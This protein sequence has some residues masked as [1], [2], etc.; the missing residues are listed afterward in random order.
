VILEDELDALARAGEAAKEQL[1]DELVSK[2][3]WRDYL[4]ATR[5]VQEREVGDEGEKPYATIEDDQRRY[6]QLDALPED[7]RPKD[8]YE[9][10][11]RHIT[12]YNTAVDERHREVEAPRRASLAE[13]DLNALIDLIRDERISAEAN[14]EFMHVYSIY[15]WLVGCLTQ[16]RALFTATR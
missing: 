15:E 7:E 8:E 13:R 14:G 11:E 12:A 5:D 3:W 9:E 10:L 4:E 2:D 6:R 16:P 1:V